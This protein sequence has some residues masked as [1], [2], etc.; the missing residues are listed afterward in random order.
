MDYS[1]M[2][3]LRDDLTQ[4]MW[5][6]PQLELAITRQTK[7]APPSQGIG[8]SVETPL[9]F[10][11]HASQAKADLMRALRDLAALVQCRCAVPVAPCT[12]YRP[13]QTVDGITWWLQQTYTRIDNAELAEELSNAVVQAMKA[14]DSPPVIIYL[15]DCYCGRVLYGDPEGEELEC[16]GCQ[17]LHRPQDL[18]RKNQDKGREL[19]VSATQAAQYVGE[20]WGVQL[21][22]DTIYKWGRR[23]KL[24]RY[25]TTTKETLWLLGEIVDLATAIGKSRPDKSVR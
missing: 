11:N 4:C 15:G 22:R 13:T 23:G 16:D 21:K 1:Q 20:V 9:Y 12:L 7:S 18:R 8:K 6:A 25:P 3:R 2:R 24:N 10:N 17:H 19:L 14:V 5:L